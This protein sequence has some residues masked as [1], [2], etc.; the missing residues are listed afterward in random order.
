[1]NP[2]MDGL[3]GE[4]RALPLHHFLVDKLYSDTLRLSML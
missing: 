3:T 1:M 4:V 2:R